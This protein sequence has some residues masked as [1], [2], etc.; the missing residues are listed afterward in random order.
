MGAEMEGET[1]P[2]DLSEAAEFLQTVVPQAGE[3]LRNYYKS[4]IT[5]ETSKGGVDF[6]TQADIEVDSFLI[7]SIR[8]QYPGSNFLT[9]E[10][11]PQDYSSHKNSSNLWV[12]DPI[13]GTSNFS[14]RNPN[15]GISIALVDKGEIKLG[16]ILLP[17]S[18]ETLIARVDSEEATLNG[19]RLQV[20]TTAEL[21][22]TSMGTDWPWDLTKRPITVKFLG[23]LAHDVRQ[24]K[25]M[26]SAVSDLTKV[27]KG[28]L[29]AYI[30]PGA[31]PWD[32]AAASL[33]IQKAGGRVTN[34]DGSVFNP[35][36][37]TILAS[38]GL[39]HDQLVELTQKA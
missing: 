26:G 22:K 20:S 29:D 16:L 32:V 7:E 10:T 19:E 1:E 36:S 27:A 18:Y 8:R 25:I 4:G 2:I 11:A 21:R 35:F 14:R 15:F 5:G 39:I 9:E 28:E 34:S 24:I 38:N 6:T 23:N 37:G 3:K 17:I 13:D 30:H 12:I 31:K 33:I